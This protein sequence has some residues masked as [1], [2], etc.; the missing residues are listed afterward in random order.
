[1][2]NATFNNISA[3]S[4]RSVLLVEET[5]VLGKTIELPPCKSDKTLSHVVSNTYLMR[6]VRTQLLQ[7]VDMAQSYTCFGKQAAYFLNMST[8]PTYFVT[9]KWCAVLFS[10]F[11]SISQSKIIAQ[12]VYN[13]QHAR[14]L[15][16]GRSLVR[17]SI[18]PNQR[19]YNFVFVATPLSTHQQ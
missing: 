18:G 19:L 1:M 6:G 12:V 14:L 2:F 17:S 9:M 8:R 13:R 16:S 15:E 10:R 4:W 3:I 11:L 7:Q 5:E